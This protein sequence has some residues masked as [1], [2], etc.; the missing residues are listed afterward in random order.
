MGVAWALDFDRR[1]PFSRM[2]RKIGLSM[3]AAM[4]WV[5]R[6]AWAFIRRP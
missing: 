1:T 5:Q 4:I 2:L 3:P 6:G